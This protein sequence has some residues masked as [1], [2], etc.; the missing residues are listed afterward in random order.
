M[1]FE[2]CVLEIR[3]KQAITEILFAYCAHLDRMD[4]DALASLFTDDCHVDYGPEERMQSNGS[5]QL[6]RDLSRMWRWKRT[7]HH[8]SNVVIT[9]DEDHRHADALSYVMAWHERPDGSTATMMGQYRDRLV[10]LGD[11]WRIAHRRQV[12]TGNDAGFDVHINPF[13]RL[14]PPESQ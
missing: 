11:Q 14:N 1:D 6:R 3:E 10:R 7:S 4:L 13:E 2:K 5:M 12:L 8:L 9:L